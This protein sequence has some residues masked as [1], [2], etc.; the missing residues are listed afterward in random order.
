[1]WFGVIADSSLWAH[2]PARASDSK[3]CILQKIAVFSVMKVQLLLFCIKEC[4]VAA[5]LAGPDI[6]SSLS[7]NCLVCQPLQLFQI[8]QSE[9]AD[10]LAA[11]MSAAASFTKIYYEVCD[12]HHG[13]PISV[14]QKSTTRRQQKPVDDWFSTKHSACLFFT[15]AQSALLWPL[16]QFF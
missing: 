15:D 16:S 2:L 12:K 4:F 13:L 6:R 3:C 10:T 11:N 14:M 9:T 8:E 5:A 7:G 1:M